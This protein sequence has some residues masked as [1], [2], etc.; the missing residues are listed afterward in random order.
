MTAAPVPG[1]Q[2]GKEVISEDFCCVSLKTMNG[3]N[4]RKSTLAVAGT[5]HRKKV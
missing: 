1:R 3:F 5:G 2:V 4:T